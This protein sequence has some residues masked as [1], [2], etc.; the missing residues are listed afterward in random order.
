M[1]VGEDEVEHVTILE[2]NET[3]SEY[4]RPPGEQVILG[5]VRRNE[6]VRD[7]ENEEFVKVAEAVAII[8]LHEPIDEDAVTDWCNSPAGKLALAH[9]FD[10]VEPDEVVMT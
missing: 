9:W 3:A 2:Y 7:D 5:G 6:H 8:E 1:N 10:H 4:D